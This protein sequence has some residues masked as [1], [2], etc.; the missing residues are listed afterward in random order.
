[1]SLYTVQNYV[2]YFVSE[3][4]ELNNNNNTVTFLAPTEL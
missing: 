4:G 2:G 1:L 3:I